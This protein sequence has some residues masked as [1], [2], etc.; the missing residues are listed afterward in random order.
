M[1]I[2][3]VLIIKH[4]SIGDI[5]MSL[6]SVSA[7]KKTYSDITILS[8]KSGHRIFDE[9]DFN[10]K[11]IIDNRSGFINTFKILLKIINQDFEIIIDLQN[12]QRTSIYLFVLKYFSNSITNGTSFFASKRYKKINLD[13]HVKDGL[14]NQLSLIGIKV[15]D[16]DVI[17]C[18]RKIKKQVII[19]PGSS[20]EGYQKRWDINNFISVMN[21]LSSM[22]ISSYVIGGT[23]ESELSN[24]I[25]KNEYIHNLINKSP[26]KIVKSLAMESIVTISNDTSAMHFIS[27]LNLPIIALMKNN[28]YSISN[29]PTSKNSS[30]IAKNNIKDI[31]IEEVI[32][33]LSKF[34]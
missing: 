26:W 13:E 3:K 24:L 2:P 17:H 33:E 12:S 27:S 22:H 23:D 16:N 14:K 20:K 11:K 7:I 8:T 1:K 9:S 10:F 29:A 19:V 32:S 15:K 4:G 30:V 5:F 18:E 28:S 34:I 25:P 6:N 21:Y 31:S